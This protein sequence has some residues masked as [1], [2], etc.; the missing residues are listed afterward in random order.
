M[1]LLGVQ[2]NG[3]SLPARCCW[4]HLSP[5]EC[6]HYLGLSACACVCVCCVV[7]LLTH[8]ALLQHEI[9]TY[10]NSPSVSP[11]RSHP[12][13]SRPLLW[14][15]CL[16]NW[17]FFFV[18]WILKEVLCLWNRLHFIHAG[19]FFSLFITSNRISGS[20]FP[21]RELVPRHD[22]RQQNVYNWCLVLLYFFIE[23]IQTFTMQTLFSEEMVWRQLLI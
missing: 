18:R 12:T 11:A 6:L 15:A 8:C 9:K 21:H 10:K 13:V 22:R 17:V 19:H 7:L 4:V 2:L 3:K 5:A 14:E 1:S 20:W 16:S 23:I